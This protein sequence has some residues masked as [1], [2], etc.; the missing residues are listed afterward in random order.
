MIYTLLQRQHS[1]LYCDGSMICEALRETSALVPQN[2]KAGIT[3]CC[4]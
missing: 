2:S 3:L 4:P 1:Q